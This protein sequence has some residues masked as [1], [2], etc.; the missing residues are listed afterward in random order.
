MKLSDLLTHDTIAIQCHNIPDADFLASGFGLYRY[1]EA[2]GKQSMFF[3][4]VRP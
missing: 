2:A 1:F 3:T 4:A